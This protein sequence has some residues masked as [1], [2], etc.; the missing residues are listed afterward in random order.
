MSK[1]VFTLLLVASLLGPNYLLEP[2][3]ANAEDQTSIAVV[4]KGDS[5]SVL[6]AMKNN[7]EA[8][9]KENVDI[10]AAAIVLSAP[11]IRSEMIRAVASKDKEAAKRLNR[12]QSLAEKTDFRDLSISP[13]EVSPEELTV[14]KHTR[15]SMLIAALRADT[16]EIGQQADSVMES[17]LPTILKTEL[18][19]CGKEC[20]MLAAEFKDSALKEQVDAELRDLEKEAEAVDSAYDLLGDHRIDPDSV[21]TPRGEAADRLA[22]LT[23]NSKASADLANSYATLYDSYVNG[24][25]TKAKV[26]TMMVELDSKKL[27]LKEKR[28]ILYWTLKNKRAQEL[29]AKRKK[30]AESNQELTEKIEAQIESDFAM[31]WPTAFE[32]RDL[33]V[34]AEALRRHLSTYGPQNSGPLSACYAKSVCEVRALSRMLHRDIEGV[35]ADQRARLQRYLRRLMEEVQGPY[36]S[37]SYIV[38]LNAE[39]IPAEEFISSPVESLASVKPETLRLSG[40][41]SDVASYALY[42]SLLASLVE[43]GDKGDRERLTE[44]AL[45][46]QKSTLLNNGHKASLNALG[47]KIFTGKLSPAEREALGSPEE[48]L[49]NIAGVV[50]SDSENDLDLPDSYR[51]EAFKMLIATT[52]QEQQ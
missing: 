52:M 4:L 28:A 1:L 42:R 34:H 11:A 32:H 33:Q 45:M 27:D 49:A 8:F 47:S 26:M 37:G 2:N 16:E 38:R 12:I 35:P 21:E 9:D 19:R 13:A 25:E 22:Q 43:A 44:L 50:H 29:A 23:A 39:K 6:N 51:Q 20:L 14:V 24:E 40:D 17:K 5:Q 31:G 41:D 30:H 36:S 18:T 46:I 3:C 10:A 48:V 15:R 7:P